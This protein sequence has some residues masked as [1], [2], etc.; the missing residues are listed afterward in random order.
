MSTIAIFTGDEGHLSIA[1]AIAETLKPYH[2]VKIF[3]HRGI[4]L[5]AYAAA[6]RYMPVA[7]GAVYQL[8]KHRSVTDL[9]FKVIFSSQKRRE[10]AKF[11]ADTKPDVCIC[12][13]FWFLPLLAEYRARTGTP[14]V[15]VLTDPWTFH[16]MLVTNQADVQLA[17]DNHTVK[18]AAALCPDSNNQAIGWLVRP[19]FAPLKTSQSALR[20]SLGLADSFTLFVSGGSEGSAMILKLLPTLFQP[21]KPI[22]VIITSGHNRQLHNLIK[23]LNQLFRRL[24][25]DV[26]LVMLPFT[27][28]LA[29]YM[30]AADVVVGKAGPNTLFES[31]AV[32]KPFVAISHMAG[33]EEGNLDLIKH[34]QIGLIEE[35]PLKLKK[36]LDR[37]ITQPKQL[38][39]FQPKLKT[40]AEFNRQAQTKLVQ[41]VA[42]LVKR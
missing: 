29:P 8:T 37:L 13:Y 11:L 18:Q 3:Y 21:P 6:Y 36:L 34:Y 12:T 23:Q 9:G 32:Q 4:E 1:Q 22:Q 7:W 38:A 30:Q 26:K 5:D 28:N 25:D 40:L 24:Q 39:K 15:N 42:E 2:T 41:L 35:H 31:V 20:K 16:T 33:Q 19:A 17:F 14:L 27:P 10:I